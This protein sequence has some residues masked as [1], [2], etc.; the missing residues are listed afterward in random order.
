MKNNFYNDGESQFKEIRGVLKQLPAIKAPDNFEYNLM[1]RIHNRN[2]GSKSIRESKYTVFGFLKPALTVLTSAVIIFFVVDYQ[3]TE[4]E[5]PLLTEPRIRENSVNSGS[6]E[7]QNVKEFMVTDKNKNNK[8]LNNISSADNSNITRVVL[9]ENDV[10]SEEKLDFPF[11][12]R[13]FDLDTRMRTESSVP[14]NNATTVLA[15]TGANRIQFE[16]FYNRPQL[17]KKVVDSL[18]NI[19]S[20]G[21]K[22]ERRDSVLKR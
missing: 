13:S 10:I 6:S 11:P 14:A 1:T 22:N 18:K 21:V 8:Q 16:G 20:L 7:K 2:F 15:G 4:I 9:G 5:D 12:D 3:T 17:S 19:D